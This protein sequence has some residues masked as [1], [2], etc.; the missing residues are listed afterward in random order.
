LII[1]PITGMTGRSICPGLFRFL[2]DRLVICG[3]FCGRPRE[4]KAED[5][6]HWTTNMI[7]VIITFNV[8]ITI[9][10][11]CL[12]ANGPGKEMNNRMEKSHHMLAS[13]E[14]RS[15]VQNSFHRKDDVTPVKYTYRTALKIPTQ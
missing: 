7:T 11:S 9:F 2:A 3:S 12:F 1:G 8:V 5:G 6:V 4:T 14:I 10:N 15:F 13:C